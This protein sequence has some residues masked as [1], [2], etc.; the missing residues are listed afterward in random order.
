MSTTHDDDSPSRPEG[1][2]YVGERYRSLFEEHPHAVIGFDAEGRLTEVNAAAGVVSGYGADLVGMNLAELVDG[3][4][5]E[6]ALSAFGRVLERTSERLELAIRRVDGSRAHLLVTG[7]PWVVN[8][9]VRGLYVI[10]EDVTERN[11]IAR[12]LEVTR[13]LAVQA[14]EAKS[15]FVA[16]MSH[17]VRTPLTSILAA[18]E[19]LA[20]TEVDVEQIELVTTLQ[21]SGARLLAL[22]DSVLDF[23]AS[24]AVDPQAVEDFDLY[25]L[26]DD[27][28]ALVEKPARL[29]GIGVDVKVSSDVPRWITDH[30]T[31]TSQILT[32]LMS[33]AVDYTDTGRVCLDVSTTTTS[34]SGP[35]ILYRVEDT[36]IGI[37]AVEQ[38][39]I[40]DAFTRIDGGRR[41]S[42]GHAGLGLSIVKQ[43]VTISG[44]SIRVDSEPGRGTTFYV[45]MPATPAEPPD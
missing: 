31:W 26:L 8:E 38:D 32:N 4:D 41:S 40:F 44:G 24:D 16:R 42:R 12:E 3:E 36:G 2:P 43:L 21:R 23:A 1:P 19:L 7:I 20:E 39:R 29:K 18:V 25:S 35:G 11:R 6:R 27:V 15:H 33:N 14:S 5:L 37:D 34:R 45:T 28:V 9:T 13:H 22:V 30:P 10:A 17:E